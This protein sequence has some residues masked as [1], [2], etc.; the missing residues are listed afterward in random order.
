MLVKNLFPSQ[1]ETCFASDGASKLNA[2]SGMVSMSVPRLRVTG[3]GKVGVEGAVYLALSRPEASR[4]GHALARL[5]S[6]TNMV[7]SLYG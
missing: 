2:S 7:L 1:L 3:S 4:V 6:S 5:E